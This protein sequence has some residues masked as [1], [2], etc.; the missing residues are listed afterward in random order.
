MHKL[1]KIPASVILASWQAIKALRVGPINA[2]AQSKHAKCRNYIDW[3]EGA[4]P[5]VKI[6]LISKPSNAKTIY[7]NP[8]KCVGGAAYILLGSGRVLIDRLHGLSARN[9]SPETHCTA[10]AA[11]HNGMKTIPYATSAFQNNNWWFQFLIKKQRRRKVTRAL[12]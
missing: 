5:C 3:A 11:W 7:T 6:P 4:R 2:A 10:L 8:V 9:H 12:E 1:P